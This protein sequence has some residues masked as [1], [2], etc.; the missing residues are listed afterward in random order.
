MG[1]FSKIDRQAA[2]IKGM[3]E[4]LDVDVAESLTR[5]PSL[6]MNFRSAV[7]NCAFCRKAR[8][9]A[10]WQAYHAHAEAPP[11]YCRNTAL[12]RNLAQH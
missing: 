1:L 7:V 5:D 6:A 4:R 11:S 10:G 9:C 3:A 12:F 8:D 2:L